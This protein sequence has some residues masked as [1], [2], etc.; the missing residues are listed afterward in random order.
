VRRGLGLALAL[1]AWFASDANAEKDLYER[2]WPRVPD[3]QRASFSDHVVDQI[4]ELGNMLGYHTSLLSHEMIALRF[5][6]RRR[7]AHVAIGGGDEHFLT[8]K[9][10][11]DVQF[12]DGLAR[13]NTRVDLS[14]RGRKIE[15]RLPEMEMV[16]ASY[17]DERGVEVRLPLFRRKF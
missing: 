2:L 8:F 16:P 1:T 13:V 14:F 12:I 9:L 7:R 5:D 10:A 17:R 4:T 11:S 3:S 6:G 15:L